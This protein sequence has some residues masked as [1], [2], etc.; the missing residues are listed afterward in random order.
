MHRSA[1]QAHVVEEVVDV[2]RHALAIY[3]DDRAS[4]WQLLQELDKRLLLL[5]SID[6]N[7]HL[8]DVGDSAPGTTNAESNVAVGK[9]GL[10][11]F[12]SVLGKGGREKQILDI[13]FFLF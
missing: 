13:A 3:E 5:R 1:W 8:L 4:W 6:L 9:V 7:H 12:S 10:G 2:V 11:K